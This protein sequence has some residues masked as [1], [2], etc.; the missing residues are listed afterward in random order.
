MYVIIS[1][2]HMC[3]GSQKEDFLDG[4]ARIGQLHY[5]A[6]ILKAKK[7]A[8]SLRDRFFSP[9]KIAEKVSNS[10]RHFWAIWG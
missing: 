9:K 5:L 3:E 6:Y 10:G 1:Q 8:E 2:E 7:F 4:T